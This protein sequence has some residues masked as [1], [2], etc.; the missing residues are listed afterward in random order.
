MKTLNKFMK[1][2]ADIFVS[3]SLL[4]VLSPLFVLISLLIFITMP[5]PIF[6]KQ[7][8]AGYKK[9]SFKIL[10]FRTMK[11]DKEAEIVINTKKDIER[12]TKTGKILRR[13]KLDELPQLFNVLYG[14]MSL[15]GPRPTIFRQ[16]DKYNDYEMKRLDVKPGMTGLAQINGG[17]NIPWAERIE[18]D[19]KY[20]EK[21]NIFIDLKIILFTVVVIVF[22]EKKRNRG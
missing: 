6:F 4:L 2:I 22:G 21:N 5:G 1:R 15:V 9:S 11:V 14:N 8:R 18:F 20:V 16:V 13:L 17:I 19:I 7:E 10:K 12:L 3:F